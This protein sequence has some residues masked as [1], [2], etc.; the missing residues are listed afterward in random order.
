MGGS[1]RRAAKSGLIMMEN[2]IFSIWLAIVITCS[3]FGATLTGFATRVQAQGFTL[4]ITTTA[5]GTVTAPGAVGEGDTVAFSGLSGYT[6][7][8]AIPNEGYEFAFWTAGNGQTGGTTVAKLANGDATIASTTIE[9]DGNYNIKAWFYQP[10]QQIKFFFDADTATAGYQNSAT[11][12]DPTVTQALNISFNVRLYVDLG[13]IPA[14]GA[15]V[16]IK[17]DGN[18]IHGPTNAALILLPGT[19]AGTLQALPEWQQV[20]LKEVHDTGDDKSQGVGWTGG[21]IKICLSGDRAKNGIV[22]LAQI[23]LTGVALTTAAPYYSS[24]GYLTTDPLSTMAGISSALVRGVDYSY[25]TFEGF[26]TSIIPPVIPVVSIANPAT[27]ITITA[28]ETVSFAA[29]L[30]SGGPVASNGWKWDFNY[31][32]GD[33]DVDAVGI[34]PAPYNWN[35]VAGTYVVRVTGENGAGSSSATR[36]VTVNSGPANKLVFKTQPSPTSIAGAIWNPFT[37]G[38]TDTYGNPVTPNGIDVSVTTSTGNFA[39]GTTTRTIVNGT[40]AFDDLATTFAGTATVI[41]SS[42]G[43][44]SATSSNVLVQPGTLDHIIINPANPSIVPASSQQFTATAY[45]QYNNQI[46]GL[47]YTWS[48]TNPSAGQIDNSSGLFT[49]GVA[50]GTFENVI[51]VQAIADGITKQSS[52]GVTVQDAIIISVIPPDKVPENYGFTVPV[53]VNHL[54]NFDACDYEVHFNPSVLRLDNVTAGNING[55]SI[56]VDFWNQTSPGVFS[57]VQNVTGFTGVSGSGSLAVFH[58]HVIGSIGNSS[59]ISFANGTIA[60][61]VD[62]SAQAVSAVWVGGTVD[63]SIEPGDANC[64]GFINALDITKTERIIVK[65]APATTGADANKDG[66]INAVDITMIE[67]IIAGL[68]G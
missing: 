23:P 24:I 29:H 52:T 47:T 37:V 8:T 34:N 32:E 54:E 48:V 3:L 11:V 33:T 65:L 18:Y 21:Y 55:I 4:T 1:K 30:D 7:I 36:T 20:K 44:V 16:Y 14:S 57:I 35:N 22:E 10:G 12:G 59:S 2:R 43:L 68:L 66:N 13:T 39:G 45:D 38:V 28:G 64:D 46:T 6:P 41:A 63:L 26:T 9:M 27:D 50:P 67:M 5:G 40:V 58:F 53:N 17:Y 31:H 61:V 51:N 49:A 42:E 56:P 15:D 62:G 25:G 60:V 19:T